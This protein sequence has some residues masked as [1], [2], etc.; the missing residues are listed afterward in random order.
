MS[1]I[2]KSKLVKFFIR[3]LPDTLYLKLAYRYNFGRK[4][5][6]KNPKT[7]NEKIQWLKLYDRKPEYIPMVDKYEAKKIIAKI[8]GDEYIIPTLGVWNSWDEIDF[9]KLPNQFVLKTTHDSGGVVIVP[10]KSKLDFAAAR[11]KIEKS[12]HHNFYL[13]GREWPYKGVK[14]RILAEEYLEDEKTKELRDYKFFV[15]NG[16]A[17]IMFVATDRQKVG[18]D[19]KFDFFDMDYNWLPIIN[20]HPN[21]A[22][23][24]E[25]PVGFELMKSL[26][27]KL[28]AGFFHIRIDFY[29]VNGR[30]YVG[31]LTFYHWS[32][33]VPFQPEEWDY[34]LGEWMDLNN[35][36]EK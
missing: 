34:K 5:D 6:L 30:V 29:E 26:S 10:D 18:E 1:F 14:P 35:S 12:L 7:Y 3:K 13:S 2:R 16:K 19:T 21:A 8:V 22:T 9:S 23:H 17:R 20:G 33:L 25:K 24:P 27:E 15:F 36:P 32:G 31:E 4:L 28:G 11:D